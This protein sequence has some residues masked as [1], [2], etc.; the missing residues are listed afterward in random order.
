MQPSSDEEA[1]HFPQLAVQAPQLQPQANPPWSPR[2]TVFQLL[3]FPPARSLE[4]A[5]GGYGCAPADAP[6]EEQSSSGEC[7]KWSNVL[8][9]TISYS[10]LPA[11]QLRWAHSG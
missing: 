4:Q 11:T 1:G 7:F 2:P 8:L 5:P 10:R 3:A 9:L 6:P